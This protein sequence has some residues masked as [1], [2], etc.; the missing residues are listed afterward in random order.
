MGRRW[1][2]QFPAREG[3]RRAEGCGEEPGA[4]LAPCATPFLLLLQL[5]C[6]QTLD[7]CCA[8]DAGS[9][10]AAPCP[11]RGNP[12]DAEVAAG[13]RMRKTLWPSPPWGRRG[14][15]GAGV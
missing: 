10:R 14:D 13:G 1:D 6:E 7:G 15:S 3:L 5:G 12:R 4:I 11:A 9:T 2:L 8:S